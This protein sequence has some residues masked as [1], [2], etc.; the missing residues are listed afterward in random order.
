MIKNKSFFIVAILS[1]SFCNLI[2]NPI[3]FGTHGETYPI[4]EE[5]GNEMIQKKVK[6]LNA[7]KIT[8]MYQKEYVSL[9]TSHVNLPNSLVDSNK[10]YRDMVKARWDIKDDNGKVIYAKGEL[11][12]SKLPYGQSVEICFINGNLQK[13][14]LQKI[15]SEFGRKCIYMVN[16]YNFEKFSKEYSLSAVY[17]MGGQNLEYVKRF[18]IKQLPT[19]I[20]KKGEYI[21]KTT[22]S[23]K[24]LSLESE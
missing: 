24:K 3:D 6:E 11:I 23:V 21:T 9:K 2:A 7:T 13:K 20:F 18:N 8:N 16:N 12:P 17:P 10:T 5:N 19:K 14:I 4:A 15:I 22:L 1:F